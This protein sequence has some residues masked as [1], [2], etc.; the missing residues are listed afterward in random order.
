VT[1]IVTPGIESFDSS[2]T[3]PAIE[4]CCANA[5]VARR[6]ENTHAT[7]LTLNGEPFMQHPF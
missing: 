3:A 6:R 5:A 2:T 4:A 1:V 7:A